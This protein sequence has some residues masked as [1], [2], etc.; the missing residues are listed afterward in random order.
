MTNDEYQERLD[1][2]M[3]HLGSRD[4]LY[5]TASEFTQLAFI[6]A[7]DDKARSMFDALIEYWQ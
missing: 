3:L 1:S 7:N 4:M 6:L 5:M 2:L